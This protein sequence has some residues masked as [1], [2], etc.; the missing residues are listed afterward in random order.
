MAAAVV[1]GFEAE[2]TSG[3]SP[4]FHEL[5]LNFFVSFFLSFFLSFFWGG[6]IGLGGS[7]GF[8]L[9]KKNKNWSDNGGNTP[10]LLFFKIPD[11]PLSFLRNCGLL[12]AST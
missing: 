11:S 8:F 9:T 3:V 7:V 10:S 4:L 1:E 2:T 5:V 12:N 6:N